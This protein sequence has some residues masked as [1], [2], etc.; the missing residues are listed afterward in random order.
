MFKQLSSPLESI[1]DS[2]NSRF[3]QHMHRVEI[4]RNI[5]T[6]EKQH[7]KEKSEALEKAG[8]LQLTTNIMIY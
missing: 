1:F 5:L 3:T 2:L 4:M 6:L 8:R 7:S